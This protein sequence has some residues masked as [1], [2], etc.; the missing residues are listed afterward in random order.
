MLRV[1][2]FVAAIEH[3]EA[4]HSFVQSQL[5]LLGSDIIV[6]NLRTL[7]DDT[8]YVRASD[9]QQLDQ[10]IAFVH[11]VEARLYTRLMSLI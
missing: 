4:A 5:E 9:E 10:S 2:A 11:K 6:T 3:V 7:N 8:G 1:L